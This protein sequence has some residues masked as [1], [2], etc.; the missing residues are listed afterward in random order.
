MDRVLIDKDAVTV[1]DFKTGR[2]NPQKYPAQMRNYLAIISEVYG[3]PAK[4]L[5]AYVDLNKLVPVI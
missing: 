2:E 5:L 4:G 3:K 1:I